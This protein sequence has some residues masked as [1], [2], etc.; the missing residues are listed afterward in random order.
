MSEKSDY[1]PDQ[2]RLIY[3]GSQLEDNLT[4]KDYKIT[5]GTIIH[6][7]PRLRG[8]AT[9]DNI[10]DEVSNFFLNK[11]KNEFSI[12]KNKDD[13]EVN[14]IFEKEEKNI[15]AKKFEKGD[16]K[17]TLPNIISFNDD[18]ELKNENIINIQNK[19]EQNDLLSTFVVIEKDEF[20]DNAKNNLPIDEN[21][22]NTNYLKRVELHV[23]LIYFDLN[24]TNKDIIFISII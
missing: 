18:K 10:K 24:M 2:Q 23:N 6:M 1:P 22:F 16:D 15:S 7:I 5:N 9:I 20:N 8:G 4:L 3:K 13:N 19:E 12:N 14:I 11:P 21:D 17:K